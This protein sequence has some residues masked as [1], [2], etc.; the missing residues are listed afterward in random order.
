MT[1]PHTPEA[2]ALY[3]SVI[4]RLRQLTQAGEFAPMHEALWRDWMALHHYLCSFRLDNAPLEHRGD[5][6]YALARRP[7]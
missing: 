5:N 6:I 2:I 4:E 1:S 7:A 3:P